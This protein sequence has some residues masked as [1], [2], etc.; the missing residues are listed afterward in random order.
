MENVDRTA[1]FLTALKSEFGDSFHTHLY[2]NG[3][4]ATMPRLRTLRDAGVDEIRFHWNVWGVR[5]ALRVGG[6]D[7]GAE[8]PALPRQLARLKHHVLTLEKAG[9]A[10]VNLNE[11][12]FSET[13][14][15]KLLARGFRLASPFGSA[16][17]GS[18][19]TALALIEW[20]RKNTQ[21]ITLH[22]CP[23]RI[24]G[25]VQLRRRFLRTAHHIRKSYE[26]VSRE[27][28]LVR[29]ELIAK[30][31]AQ[32]ELIAKKLGTDGFDIAGRK[33]L[34]ST[35]VA[36]KYARTNNHIPAYIVKTYPSWDALEIERIP[37]KH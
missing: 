35:D 33:V 6:W 29:G 1:R 27:G 12:D 7:V 20:A 28:L 34:T 25:G 19:E 16:V 17:S 32:A 30:S 18:R 5:N 36:K 21:K 8:V 9:A 14:A 26:N 3:T 22:F 10:F 31:R 37:L 24:K 2:T 13:N 15:K 23:S 11:L 4:R